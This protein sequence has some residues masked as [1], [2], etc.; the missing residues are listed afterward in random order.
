MPPKRKKIAKSS[1]SRKSE[2]DHDAE[3]EEGLLPRSSTPTCTSNEEG[4]VAEAA[5]N[6]SKTAPKTS[7]SASN[8]EA[9]AKNGS[10]MPSKTSKPASNGEAPVKR[11]KSFCFSTDQEEQLVAWME[12]NPILYNMKLKAYHQ[13]KQDRDDLFKNECKKYVQENTG[14]V[15]TGKL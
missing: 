9:A 15:C 5:E 3:T 14:I 10:K 8:G 2:S 6:G 7:K 4:G 1:K 11:A 13:R 12:Q